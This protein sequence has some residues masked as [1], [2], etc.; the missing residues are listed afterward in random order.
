MSL[1]TNKI[2]LFTT[3]YWRLPPVHHCLSCPQI[4]HFC[5]EDNCINKKL[6]C[7]RCMSNI[8]TQVEF[9]F[10]HNPPPSPLQL[11]D[12]EEDKD[13][14]SFLLGTR[15]TISPLYGGTPASIPANDEHAT[16]T[17]MV[18][19]P[20]TT[21]QTVSQFISPTSSPTPISTVP[22]NPTQTTLS[23]VSII[24]VS[25]NGL[26]EASPSEIIHR[27]LVPRQY[28]ASRK[29]NSDGPRR[30]PPIKRP[31]I[32]NQCLRRSTSTVVCRKIL[33]DK[34]S[35]MFFSGADVEIPWYLCPITREYECGI[36]RM[37]TKQ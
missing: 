10:E 11:F 26:Q 31:V 22:T 18:D 30:L 7:A 27:N 35:V 3:P 25:N 24:D 12:L 32:C 14:T 21:I 6:Q 37:K 23:S 13:V 29:R 1:G 2:S 28:K 17:V 15:E 36:C 34:V 5:T 20:T 9:E 8:L 33:H 4:I 16:S 19:A